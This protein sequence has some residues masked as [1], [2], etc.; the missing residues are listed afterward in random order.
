MKNLFSITLIFLFAATPFAQQ[1]R[2]TLRTD[3]I[4]VVKPY[5]PTIS[6]A[7]KLKDNPSIDNKNQQKDSI[8]YSFFS[9]PVASTFTPSKGKA[10][11]VVREPI[12][13]IYDNFVAVG[14]G[15]YTTPHVEAFVHS[16]SSRSNDF[17]AFLKHHS[18]S[19]GIKDV[20]VDDNFSDTHL[21]LFY[22]QFERD[23]NWETQLGVNHQIFNWYGLPQ[24]ITYDDNFISS[25]V[26][27]QSYLNVFANGKIRFESGIFKGGDLKINYF[28][29]DYS[30]SGIQASV[31]PEIEF[32]ISSELIN[33]PTKIEYITGSFNQNYLTNDDINYSFLNIGA[34]PGL[35]VLRDNL[36]INLGARVYYSFDLENQENQFYA[37][38]NITASYKI[39]EEALIAYAGATGDL[40]QNSYREFTQDNPFVAPT[41]NMQQT[42]QQYNAFLGAK[43]KLAAN[44]GYNFKASYQSE[45]NKAMFI[46]NPTKTDGTILPTNAYE[47]GNSFGVIYDD[48]KTLGVAANLE[49]YISKEL[50]VDGN[51]TYNNFTTDE[52][53]KAWNLPT[54]TATAS[55][56]YTTKKWYAGADLYF[57]NERY[58]FVVPFGGSPEEV[59]LDAYV[60]L[61][62]NGGYKFTDRLSAFVRLNNIISTN[63]ERYTN[64]EVQGIQALGG[65]IYKFDF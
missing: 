46:N 34:S 33:M 28:G 25:I 48:V 14:F 36:S 54:L 38:P 11:S 4:V 32:P 19:G 8:T 17:G 65:V 3:E 61:N 47:A 1:E 45:R 31:T 29:D 53:S 41:L 55:A 6:D 24:D 42:D 59:K 13:K 7:F 18:S 44:V 30:S 39:M 21:T 10:Q 2:D 22:K 58:D 63:Y 9:V 43:G 51:V 64:F 52:Q 35:E 37:Y 57:A 20:L 40:E 12:D 5:T 49:F 16:S 26:P 27:K 62:L 60:D 50:T 15:N 23:Y 56:N